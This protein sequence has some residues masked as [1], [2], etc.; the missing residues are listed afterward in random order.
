M[1]LIK[2]AG[3]IMRCAFATSGVVTNVHLRVALPGAAAD[4]SS[5][6]REKTVGRLSHSKVCALRQRA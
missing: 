1:S 6:E 2:E 5:D 3:C 4:Q